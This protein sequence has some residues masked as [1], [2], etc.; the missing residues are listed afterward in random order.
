LYSQLPLLYSG[1]YVGLP[2]DISLACVPAF[3][4]TCQQ[5]K[6]VRAYAVQCS[7]AQCSA[8]QCSAVQIAR[9]IDTDARHLIALTFCLALFRPEGSQDRMKRYYRL[10]FLETVMCLLKLRL[11]SAHIG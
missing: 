7:A 11:Y 2:N 9:V 3:M 10:F 8:A 5:F 1:V 6:H 4:P